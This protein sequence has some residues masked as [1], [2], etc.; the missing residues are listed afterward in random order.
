MGM[1][2]ESW[3]AVDI[4]MC[5]R[6]LVCACVCVSALH[7]YRTC[8]TAGK[9]EGRFI[10]ETGLTLLKPLEKSTGQTGHYTVQQCKY[11]CLCIYIYNY[12]DIYIYTFYSPLFISSLSVTSCFTLCTKSALKARTLRAFYTDIRPLSARRSSVEFLSDLFL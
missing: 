11:L 4:T 1:Q 10:V 3:V 5:V 7:T 6:V 2:R 8:T 9:K 12:I